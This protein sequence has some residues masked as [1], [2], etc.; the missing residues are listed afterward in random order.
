MTSFQFR[1]DVWTEIRLMDRIRRLL[2]MRNAM[3]IGE[4]CI[5]LGVSEDAVRDSLDAMHAQGEVERLRPVNYDGG[6]QDFFRLRH[7]PA[8][9]VELRD[10]SQQNR[11][12][13][14]AG[15]ATACA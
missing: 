2:E 9:S 4:L 12:I 7:A 6:D 3:H 10:S 15:M 11:W 14:A 8:A 5:R 1:E 13:S